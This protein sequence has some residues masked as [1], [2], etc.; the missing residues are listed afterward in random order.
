MTDIPLPP[1][2]RPIAPPDEAPPGAPPSAAPGAP[3]DIPILPPGLRAKPPPGPITVHPSEQMPQM[4]GPPPGPTGFERFFTAEGR[5][6]DPTTKQPYREIRDLVEMMP[7]RRIPGL[8]EIPYTGLQS[9]TLGMMM[10]EPDEGLRA[11]W[12]A[13]KFQNAKVRR[14]GREIIIDIPDIDP[15]TG[16]PYGAF[17]MNQ[18]GMSPQDLDEIVREGT[19]M[20]PAARAFGWGSSLVRRAL[21][22]GAA[23][24]VTE[25]ARQGV[26]MLGGARKTIDAPHVLTSAATAAILGGVSEAGFGLLRR[27]FATKALIGANGQM[28]AQA[29][30]ILARIGV[31]PDTVTLQTLRELEPLVARARNPEE[32]LRLAQAR[33]LDVPVTRGDISRDPKLQGFEQRVARGGTYGTAVMPNERRLF[34]L[35][36]P[37]GGEQQRALQEA[38]NVTSQ[39]VS[40]LPT[41]FSANTGRVA[42]PTGSSFEVVQQNLVQAAKDM[43]NQFKSAYQEAFDRGAAVMPDKLRALSFDLQ[44]IKEG[45]ASYP[46]VG[47]V[48]DDL[49]AIIKEAIAGGRTPVQLQQLE[50][51]IRKSISTLGGDINGSLRNAAGDMRGA[52]T[53]WESA[54]TPDDFVKGGPE[55]VQAFQRG[56]QIRADYA[57]RFEDDTAIATMLKAKRMPPTTPGGKPT[58][59]IEMPSADAITKILNKSGDS[60]APTLE[61]LKRVLALAEGPDGPMWQ[62]VKREAFAN[63]AE[64]GASTF[65]QAWERFAVDSPKTARILFGTGDR[66]HLETMAGVGRTTTPVP[67]AV[68]YPNTAYEIARQLPLSNM[69]AALVG[70]GL[71]GHTPGAL[72]A[73]PLLS[74]RAPGAVRFGAAAMGSEFETPSPEGVARFLRSQLASPGQ[75]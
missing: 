38:M 57:S 45:Y 52:Y 70:R 55:A 44:K 1:G 48:A 56:R 35:K 54:L 49:A 2:L 64:R 51:R 39:R 9:A 61:R 62:R 7:E 6:I 69:G 30:L 28:T 26:S 74:V 4:P 18:V 46:Q 32:A 37:E 53:K 29:P 68:N 10:F 17:T 65:S 66:A 31:D 58:W 67:G 33:T 8:G 60:A 14:D 3:P 11:E 50:E 22:G 36:K 27:A 24:G 75:Q 73:R 41:Q 25:A 12:L 71:S 20:G 40:G 5:A 15:K 13:K 63:L 72:M 34:E 23:T 16:K 59:E 42:T 43:R 21:A 19:M 47:A